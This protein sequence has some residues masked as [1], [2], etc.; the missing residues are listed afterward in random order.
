MKFSR[1]HTDWDFSLGK[2]PQFS[3]A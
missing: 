1:L 3:Q 2:C